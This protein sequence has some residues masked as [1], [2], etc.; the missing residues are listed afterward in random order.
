LSKFWKDL[1]GDH[2]E[3]LAKAIYRKDIG[4]VED[5]S[6]IYLPLMVLPRALTSWGIKNIIPIKIDETKVLQVPGSDAKLEIRKVLSD[7]YNGQLVLNGKIIHTFEKIPFPTVCG[8]L[9]SVLELYDE[10]AG[11][12]VEEVEKKELLESSKEDNISKMIDKLGDLIDKVVQLQSVKKEEAPLADKKDQQPVIV[13]VNL[14]NIGNPV[15]PQ[16][17][18][19]Q[20]PEETKKAELTADAGKPNM[21]SESEPPKMLDPEPNLSQPDMEKA[22]EDEMA[23]SR[24]KEYREER[25]KFEGHDPLA[26]QVTSVPGVSDRGIEARR[27]DPKPKAIAHGY[28]RV[29]SPEKHADKAKKYFK[30]VA[31][32]QRSIQAPNLPKAELEKVAF[33]NNRPDPEDK[34][35]SGEPVSQETPKTESIPERRT[36]HEK[37][38]DQAKRNARA[39][40]KLQPHT[41]PKINQ[42]S[43]E[44]HR[45]KIPKTDVVDLNKD[46]ED[47]GT[48]PKAM[49]NMPK[50][51]TGPI[52]PKRDK[53]PLNGM[54]K[55]LHAPKVS[56]PKPT[57]PKIPKVPGTTVVTSST[58]PALK[59]EMPV[60]HNQLEEVKSDSGKRV[61]HKD[62]FGQWKFN[63]TGVFSVMTKDSMQIKKSEDG[64]FTIHTD[65]EQ[66]DVDNIKLLHMMLKAKNLF[67]KYGF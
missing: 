39:K 55:G 66:W 23:G 16:A 27:A 43:Q 32:K 25:N 3:S 21:M 11:R 17:E 14:S 22:R 50:V 6:E 36:A 49:N 19:A 10:V 60:T 9:M 61:F 7:I 35:M 29:Q 30:S 42:S 47:S 18:P 54:P 31:D 8:T 28:A 45:S 59:S 12:P 67:K 5:P 51:P 24:K 65:P 63:P 40:N 52:K 53:L 1:G 44:Q 58:A 41:P 13:N 64:S 33:K 56:S 2:Y 26:S 62:E 37:F 57:L 34:P 20:K 38:L 15:M 46:A 4:Q 48:A